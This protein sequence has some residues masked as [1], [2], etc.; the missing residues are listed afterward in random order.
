MSGS[1]PKFFLKAFLLVLPFC[2]VLGFIEFKLK[3]IP[4]S[5]NTKKQYLEKQVKDIKVLV[6]GSSE[7]VYNIDPTY[8]SQPGFNLANISQSLYYDNALTRKYFDQMTSL[9]CII[10]NMSYFSLWYQ[11]EDGGEGWRDF[12]YLHFW[13]IRYPGI[14]RDDS[15]NYSLI[16]LYSP[17][18]VSGFARKKFKVNLADNL[19]SNGYIR[20]DT[21]PN[22][23]D[24]TSGQIR[25]GIHDKHRK[26][27]HFKENYAMLENFAE[28]CNKRKIKL[29]FI[30]SPVLPTYYNYTDPEANQMN[31]DAI[32]KL[33]EKYNC[34]Y[35][36]YFKDVRFS[37]KDYIDHDH[38][39]FVGA[40][41]F[42]KILNEDIVSK[43]K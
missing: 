17:K 1:I 15:K 7:S 31:L 12:Y 42:S 20:N 5:Y 25:V 28:E 30:S 32:N 19:M 36:N 37:K 21:T 24:E 26:I 38:M 4:N 11:V 29:V 10:L 9:K 27:S 23:T 43:I 39:N 3:Q 6:L 14:K 13:D 16:M 35:F 8:F 22:L 18:I 2:L 34:E 41:K 40:A 33:C